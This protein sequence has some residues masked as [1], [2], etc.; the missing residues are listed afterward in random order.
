VGI[1]QSKGC[2]RLSASLKME[3]ELAAEMSSAFTKLDNGEENK[4]ERRRIK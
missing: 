3:T 2:N 1:A 4:R